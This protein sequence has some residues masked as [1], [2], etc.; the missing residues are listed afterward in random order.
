MNLPCYGI[1]KDYPIARIDLK[2]AQGRV[3]DGYDLT[4]GDHDVTLKTVV[5]ANQYLYFAYN[6]ESN[7]K[8]WE[9][10]GNKPTANLVL[11]SSEWNGDTSLDTFGGNH[12]LFVLF[13][14]DI[15]ANVNK[16]Y[17]LL[18]YKCQGSFNTDV[19]IVTEAGLY[20]SM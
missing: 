8:R 7:P 14:E 17:S 15:N 16:K 13:S 5:G 9:W 4:A 18:H 3:C 19:G 10:V 6:S 20:K 2:N 11:F 12:G 1:W